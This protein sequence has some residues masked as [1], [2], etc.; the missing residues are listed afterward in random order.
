MELNGGKPKHV[1]NNSTTQ[2]GENGPKDPKKNDNSKTSKPKETKQTLDK[3][4]KARVKGCFSPKRNTRR[5]W[6]SNNVS[7]S[8]K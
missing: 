2:S 6:P 3:K 8:Y 7:F 5:T 4:V 1:T